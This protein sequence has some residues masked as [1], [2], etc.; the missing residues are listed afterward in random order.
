MISTSRRDGGIFWACNCYKRGNIA[1]QQQKG[2]H[3][4]KQLRGTS[5]NSQS[6]RTAF[7]QNL[8]SSALITLH[9]GDGFDIHQCAAVNLPKDFGVELFHQFFDGFANQ[10]FLRFKVCTRVYL[11]SLTQNSTSSTATI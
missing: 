2:L 1:F 6:V 7:D 9:A 8:L 10:K 3:A 5:A 4:A 11:S